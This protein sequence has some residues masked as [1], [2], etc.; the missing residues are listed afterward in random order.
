M[1]PLFAAL[2]L[3][4]STL[5]ALAA[6]SLVDSTQATAIDL[7]GRLFDAYNRCDISAFTA[8]FAPDVEFY[9][10]TGG[11]TYTRDEAVAN[12]KK[13]ICGKVRRELV[14][15]TLQAY[16]IK[17]YGLLVTGEH[18]FC[19]LANGGGCEG[20]AEFTILWQ[21]QGDS[22]RATRVLS[23]GHRTAP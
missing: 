6:E 19:E 21:R 16:P 5:P 23:Y 11:V 20:I 13:Y 1:R 17:D 10:D 14:P 2:L 12:T 7:D 18:R 4:C 8:L 22:W 9:H 3:S 15:G